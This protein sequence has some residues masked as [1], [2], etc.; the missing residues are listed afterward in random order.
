MQVVL[1]S[2]AKFVHMRGSAVSG[3]DYWLEQEPLAYLHAQLQDFKHCGLDALVALPLQ[4]A[5]QALLVALPCMGSCL[6]YGKRLL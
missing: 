1:S 2:L 4:Q 6:V 5:D 3:G